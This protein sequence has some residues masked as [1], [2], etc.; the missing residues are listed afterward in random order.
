MSNICSWHVTRLLTFE[1]A[2][3]EEQVGA[4]VDMLPQIHMTGE[5]YAYVLWVFSCSFLTY[6]EFEQK[7][8]VLSQKFCG[9]I[10]CFK[11]GT[12]LRIRKMSQLSSYCYH[13]L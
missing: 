8:H 6:L 11:L 9:K 4:V 13:L 2:Y 1:D 3:C 10:I 7:L 12:N 5:G